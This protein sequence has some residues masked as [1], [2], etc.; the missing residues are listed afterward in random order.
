M[1][2]DRNVIQKAEKI[3]TWNLSIEIQQMWHMKCF[4]IFVTI[5]DTGIVMKCLKTYVKTI[6]EQHSVDSLQKN[7]HTRNI[8]HHKAS[9]TS[10]DLKPEWWGSPLSQE[11]KYQGNDLWQENNNNKN[12]EIV[13]LI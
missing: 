4:V 8:T 5:G 7:R 6:P 13:I 1:P 3:K 10:W 9:A 12:T 11:E 2:L